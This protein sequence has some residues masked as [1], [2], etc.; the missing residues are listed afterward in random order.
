MPAEGLSVEWSR[1]DRRWTFP[2]DSAGIHLLWQ[3]LS[4]TFAFSAND[5]FLL[6]GIDSPA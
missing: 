3:V 1:G 4:Q 5:F 6:G 2:N